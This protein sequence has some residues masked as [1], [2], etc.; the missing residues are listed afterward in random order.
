MCW[1]ESLL[2]Y[3]GLYTNGA[4]DFLNGLMEKYIIHELRIVSL[5]SD[6][7]LVLALIDDK[8]EAE[9][10]GVDDVQALFDVEIAGEVQDRTAEFGSVNILTWS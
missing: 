2:T 4:S 3:D 9:E 7:V 8:R 6:R 10:T 5:G 1:V